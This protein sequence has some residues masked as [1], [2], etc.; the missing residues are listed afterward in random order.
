MNAM[1]KGKGDEQR[2]D[3]LTR[4]ILG[5]LNNENGVEL[6]ERY[7]VLNT[8]F[9]A[10][11]VI[12]ALD[13]V[14]LQFD[15][16]ERI[17]LVTNKLFNVLFR[18]L[19][20]TD[21]ASWRSIP[22]FH[23]L[24]RDNVA[25]KQ[26]LDRMRPLLKK[27]NRGDPSGLIEQLRNEFVSLGKITAHYVAMQNIV[28]PEM[29]RSYPSHRCLQILW[30]F[31]DDVGRNIK[32]TIELLDRPEFDLDRFNEMS[33]K[34][35]FNIHTVIFRE[36]NIIFPLLAGTADSATFDS[37]LNQLNELKLP[38]VEVN[39]TNGMVQG[40]QLSVAEGRVVLPTGELSLQQLELM[41]NHLPV[42]ITFVD[43]HNTVRYFSAPRNRIF[44]RTTGIIGR[45]VQ[46]CHPPESVGIVNRIVEAFKKGEKDEASFWLK[47]GK[48]FVLIRYFAVR[49][50]ENRY[51]GV[52]EVSQEISEIQQIKGERRLLDW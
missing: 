47:L 3:K 36:E 35:F 30:S 26:K 5:L 6:L 19:S 32:R 37:M 38:F 21:T 8:P 7:R 29:E 52:L 9:T 42:D 45:K 44:P 40:A 16:L 4:Y 18:R 13:A 28:F 31:H 22:F 1:A 34:V 20:E 14:M 41:L 11:D 15:D 27:I 24:F 17:K 39:V 12:E 50:S 2:V 43:E 33:S 48:R 49:D 46:N 23:Y 51:R 10:Y 25:I